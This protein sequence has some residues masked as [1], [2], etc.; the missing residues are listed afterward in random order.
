MNSHPLPL[1]NPVREIRIGSETVIVKE[2]SWPNALSFFNKLREQTRL[3]LDDKGNLV[4]DTQKVLAAI[5]DNLELA[6][7]LVEKSTGREKAWIESLMLSEML[8]VLTACLE[9]NLGVI[10]DKIKNVRSRLASMAAGEATQKSNPTSAPSA[11][12]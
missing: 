12:P 9:V 10:A 11:T 1:F 6:T 7:W 4:L 3:L 8:D 5:G 2:L